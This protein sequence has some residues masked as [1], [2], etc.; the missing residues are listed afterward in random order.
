MA[1]VVE[2]FQNPWRG[3]EKWAVWWLITLVIHEVFIVL[4]WTP[5]SKIAQEFYILVTLLTTNY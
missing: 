5:S 1:L 3:A 2:K 4:F